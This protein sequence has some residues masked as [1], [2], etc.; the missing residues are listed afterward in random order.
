[1]KRLV[2]VLILAALN[3]TGALA[4]TYSTH[5]VESGRRSLAYRIAANIGTSLKT[6][7]YPK[8]HWGEFVTDWANTGSASF[9]CYWTQRGLDIPGGGAVEGNFLYGAHPSPARLY[10]T[11][12]GITFGINLLNHMLFTTQE[13]RLQHILAYLPNLAAAG[14]HIY[15]GF[16]NRSVVRQK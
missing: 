12:A 5:T 15:D 6:Q 2:M 9:D 7:V 8:G 3:C 13:T 16:Q 10:G 1:M 4:Q 11:A 14:I